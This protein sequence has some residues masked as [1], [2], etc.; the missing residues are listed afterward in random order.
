MKGSASRCG[1]EKEV[2]DWVDGEGMAVE[3]A[4][5]MRTRKSTMKR[6]GRKKAM[7]KETEMR[8]I[9]M[10]EETLL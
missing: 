3:V 9:M 1:G 5:E 7:M 10:M 4:R 6:I 8:E 2:G